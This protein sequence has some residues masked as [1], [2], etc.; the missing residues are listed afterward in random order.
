MS[1]YQDGNFYHVYNRGCNRNDIF[2]H[3]RNYKYLIN[4]FLNNS[5]KHKID[6]T[7]FCLMP[8]HYHLLLKQDLNGSISN[9]LKS[10]FTSYTLAINKEQKRSGTLFEGK[11]KKKLID[12]IQYIQ[13]VIWYIHRN[14]VN[15]GIVSFPEEWQFSNYLEF[16]GKRKRYFTDVDLIV[17]LY[18]SQKGYEMFMQK[19]EDDKRFDLE[20]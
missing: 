5:K 12:K 2:F 18:G 6:L 7:A 19:F 16:I 3:Q 8:N 9:F 1:F 20:L 13:Y 14:P 10:T 11:P 17:D 15:A 4:L